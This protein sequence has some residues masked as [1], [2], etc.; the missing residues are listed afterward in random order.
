MIFKNLQELLEEK[1]KIKFEKSPYDRALNNAI[2]EQK[3]SFRKSTKEYWAPVIETYHN[4]V[5]KYESRINA[6]NDILKNISSIPKEQLIPFILECIN[7]YEDEKYVTRNL[8][9]SLNAHLTLFDSIPTYG[10]YQI[11]FPKRLL[12]EETNLENSF[13]VSVMQLAYIDLFKK[14]NA[15]NIMIP[16][17]GY[18]NLLSENLKFLT[19]YKHFPYLE[20]IGINIMERRL[21]EP[22][23]KIADILNDELEEIKEKKITKNLCK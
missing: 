18:I 17:E 20:E 1:E 14:N 6:I 16:T 7:L 9:L 21:R 13:Y 8:V 10:N 23:K 4:I 15:K 5:L 12:E 3:K 11:Y 22:D 2:T 19:Y